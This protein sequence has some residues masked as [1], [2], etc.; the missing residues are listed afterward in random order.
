MRTAVLALAV[1]SAVLG[2]GGAIVLTYLVAQSFETDLDGRQVDLVTALIS[3]LL[4]PIV[5]AV[6]TVAGGVAVAG[7]R[8]PR[9]WAVVF[10]VVAVVGAVSAGGFYI[11]GSVL[12]LVTGIVALFVTGRSAAS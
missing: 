3:R 10:V 4:V 8:A 11:L 6:V 7:G 1:T 9:I 5:L 2:L 12:A